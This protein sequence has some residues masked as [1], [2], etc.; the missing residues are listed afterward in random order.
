MIV[1]AKQVGILAIFALIG[2]VL[3]RIGKV[4]TEHSQLL[5]TLVVYACYPCTVFKTF[6]TQFNVPYLTEKY[7]SILIS[8]VMFAAVV[9]AS[10][11]LAKK[12]TSKPYERNV[13]GYTMIVPNTGYVGSALVEH[14]YGPA[15]LLNQM[16]FNLPLSF[17]TYTE[18]YRMLTGGDKLTLKR[19]FNPVTSAILLG[20]AVG[21]F[22]IPLPELLTTVVERANNC[23]AP[24][25]MILT[26]IAI[27]EFDL[28]RLLKNRMAYLMTFL[29]LLVIPFVMAGIA[30]VF[31]S[32][33]IV[34]AAVMMY[35]MPCGLNTII[36]PKLIGE[37]CEIGACLA[38]L[39]NVLAIVTIPL[40]T[41]VF[42]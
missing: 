22:A 8:T 23:M 25:S 2:Y 1:V 3:A 14:L 35:A 12:M 27:S 34:L 33:E 9:I 24:L 6:S 36:F 11:W 19:L 26:G 37:D 40:C 28:S 16:M 39:S 42:L 41:A 30:S 17:F 7:S 20:C 38:L 10:K 5:S 31:F 32:R 4:K 15:V 21:I 29:R 13:Y 18:G